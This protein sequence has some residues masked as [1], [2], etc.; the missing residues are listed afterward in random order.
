MASDIEIRLKT[1]VDQAVADMKKAE[2]AVTGLDKAAD[3][4]QK[5]SSNW[6]LSLTGLNSA[7]QIASQVV[8][9][10]K[11][12]Y[13]KIIGST[14]E[15][16]DQ[17]DSLSR[18]LGVSA[19]EAS[20]L[21]QVTD[22]VF[23]S[24]EALT[25]GMRS[26]I[27]KG[28]DPSIEGLKDL[29]DKYN[30][31]TDPIARSQFLIETFGKSGLEMGKLLEKGA[32]GIDSMTAAAQK[33][34][35]IMSKDNVNAA[36][37]YKEAMDSLNDAVDSIVY[38]LGMQ[39]LPVL[40][41]I[42]VPIAELIQKNNELRVEHQDLANEL[43]QEAETWEEFQQLVYDNAEGLGLATDASDHFKTSAM[44]ATGEVG[45][46]GESFYE[47]NHAQ[48]EA[49]TSTED[50][51]FATSNYQTAIENLQTAQENL[52]SSQNSWLE[53]TAN[54]VQ[55]ALEDLKLPAE[56]YAAALLVID[57]VYGTSKTAEAEHEAKVK[58]IAQAYFDSSGDVNNF[59]TDLAGLRDEEMPTT[60]DEVEI[61]RKKVVELGNELD[62][63]NG[64]RVDILVNI[65]TTG[66][67]PDVGQFN[68]N[69]PGFASGGSFVVPNGYENDSY[70]FGVSSQEKVSV[71]PANAMNDQD[72]LLT[73]IRDLLRSQQR[74]L[75]AED[76]AL[77]MRDQ[78]QFLAAGS[79]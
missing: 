43:A 1:V 10:A 61:L 50:I 18:S 39:L 17:V 4:A 53:N 21:I 36:K 78:F 7:I 62:R 15:Y 23:I 14:I 22:D 56:Q 8:D 42:L 13:D 3:G 60:T 5:S 59:A 66:G 65:K 79:M 11:Q 45:K 28:I 52:E 68:L 25:A 75:T 74:G 67:I 49:T 6:A 70:A 54:D 16:T 34:G 26:A 33:S 37:K 73:E 55:R 30:S 72:A 32:D 2:S 44:V 35:L 20:T 51:D 9:A 41:D 76:I 69:T 38:N 48:K 24:Q 12:A 19:E 29:A 27:S 40:T 77:A 57:E 47:L 63:Q 31:I 58:E 46:Y 64:R 71:T